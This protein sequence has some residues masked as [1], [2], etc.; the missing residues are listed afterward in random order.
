MNIKNKIWT[1]ITIVSAFLCMFILV[2][3][4]PDAATPSGTGTPEITVNMTDSYKQGWIKFHDITGYWL[5]QVPDVQLLPTS[6]FVSEQRLAQFDFIGSQSIFNSMAADLQTLVGQAP[7]QSLADMKF[8]ELRKTVGNQ[9]Y[10]GHIYI[11]FNSQDSEIDVQFI[12]FPYFTV[13][14]NAT[15]GGSFTMKFSGK[16]VENNELTH[17][18]GSHIELNATPNSGYSFV[19]WYDGSTLLSSNASYTY[20]ISADK[21]ITA[22]FEQL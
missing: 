3:C 7:D 4:N 5:T 11:M 10:G 20:T 2:S 8:W 14:A 15:Q 12:L 9:L 1:I 6:Q 17:E 22:K 18:Q 19:G 13:R 16:P 21:T